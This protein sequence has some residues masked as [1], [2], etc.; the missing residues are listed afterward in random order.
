M[1]TERFAVCFK[2]WPEQPHYEYSPRFLGEDKF[3]VWGVCEKGDPVFRSGEVVF[4]RPGRQLTLIPRH[5]WWSAIWYEAA[6]EQYEV[7][8]DIGTPPRWSGYDAEIVDLDFDVRRSRDGSVEILD[9]DEFAADSIEAAYPASIIQK[10]HLAVEQV[11]GL[12]STSLLK[13]HSFFG[14]YLGTIAIIRAQ[15]GVV[16]TGPEIPVSKLELRRHPH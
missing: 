2:K 15:P 1:S 5:S 16:L 13:T 7:Y 11:R 3:G 14:G 12:M 6:E 4:Y 8:V 10:S 9:E